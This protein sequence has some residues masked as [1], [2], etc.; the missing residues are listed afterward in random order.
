MSRPNR[1]LLLTLIAGL[2]VSACSS[3]TPAPTIPAEIPPPD[4]EGYPFGPTSTPFDYTKD[5][6]PEPESTP[7]FLELAEELEIPAPGEDTGILTGQLLTPGPGGEPYYGTVYL[8]RTIT[9]D[10]EGMP[11]IVAFSEG[12][13][14]VAEQDRSGRFI[15]KDIQPG[16]YALVIWTPV[17]STVIADQGTGEYRTF[18]VKAGEVTDVGI[19]GIP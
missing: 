17:A 16:I 5:G 7:F 6:Y 3:A 19:I 4:A 10:Q 18:E 9:T 13:D 15:L 14:P 1:L 11:P 2:L 12:V 8:A